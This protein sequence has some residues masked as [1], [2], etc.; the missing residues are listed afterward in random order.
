MVPPADL[1]NRIHRRLRTYCARAR[2]RLGRL[3]AIKTGPVCLSPG[4]RHP[5][6]ASRKAHLV[7][8]Y[9]ELF[10]EAVE[11][12]LDEAR[13]LLQH[14]FTFL[15]FV[16]KHEGS[17]AWARDPVSGREW[18][19]EFSAD[20]AYRGPE[21]LGDIKL[22]WELNKHQYF[23]TLGKAAWLTGEEK[24][25][26][27]IVRQIDQWIDDNPF[28]EGINWISAL[29]AGTRV[30]SWILAFPFYA[31]EC[32]DA[33]LTKLA[34]SMAQ[35][36]VFVEGHLST[37]AYPN[38]HL[39]GEAV[40]LVFGG[41]FIDCKFS[42][43]WLDMGISILEKE[44]ERQCTS[45]GVHVER[46]IAYHRFFLD[47]YYLV[48]A[49][50]SVNG[51]GLSKGAHQN[52]ELMTEFL[53]NVI[54]PDG[55]V[56]GFGDCDDARA[57]WF[58]ADAPTDYQSLLTLGAVVY[59]RGDFK[60]VA[61]DPTEELLWLMGDR[62]IAQFLEMESQLPSKCSVAYPEGGYFIMRGGWAETDPVLVFDCGPLGHGPAG[63]GHADA[64][65]FQLYAGNYLFLAD[66]GTFSYNLDYAWRDTFRSTKAHNTVSLDGQD[67][68]VPADRMSWRSMA[69]ASSRRWLTTRWFDL[70]DGEHDGY[71]RLPDSV[72][73]RRVIVFIKPD[74]WIIWDQFLGNGGHD[75]EFAL[76]LRPDCTVEVGQERTSLT[77]RSPEG[78]RLYA[79][80][81]GC[82][83]EASLPEIVYGSEGER[84][85]WFSPQYGTRVPA[86]AIR[87]RRGFRGR[88]TLMTCLSTSHTMAPTFSE[89]DPP[90][91]VE[92]RGREGGE[93]TLFY[94]D[95]V[96]WTPGAEGIHFD[97]RL[98][99]RR[100]L[101]GAP[102]IFWG[103]DFCILS[104]D[105]LL[106]VR[107]P[108]PIESFSLEDDHC[109]LTIPAEHAGDLRI[110]AREGV[111]LVI[112][113]RP[114]RTRIMAAQSMVKTL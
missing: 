94:R 47:Q 28:Y 17:I 23:F 30:V 19:R 41:L 110:V 65:S 39:V 24:F 1:Y 89:Q 107:S 112:N 37:G 60:K 56:P 45:D 7:F 52:I 20:I 2:Y 73:H 35:H 43:K 3:P 68:S 77:L 42:Q 70:V 54:L 55:S 71:H 34:Q 109:E 69:T 50:L 114:A 111:R 75:L 83:D 49:F 97:G 48:N 13:R 9:R 15:G 105:G 102:L 92:L 5:I 22:P 74:T 99:Y 66:S 98:L 27:E 14:Q 104:I 38:T 11:A 4:F 108:V 85:A 113:G 6:D 72:T 40:V 101:P 33:F 36:M 96:G 12:E 16:M 84:S 79:H 59:D 51:R 31:K 78:S 82:S 87:V 25:A 61:R 100:K 93:E 18:S 67:Q 46:S 53:R 21:R 62:G 103:G 64:L 58:R 44:I 95:D 26:L 86:S 81:L 63:H 8:R 32:D 80:V 91:R 10:P 90:F 106:D 29:E 76:H 57:L 88:A